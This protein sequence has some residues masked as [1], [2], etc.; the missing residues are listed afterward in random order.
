MTSAQLQ[1]IRAHEN[2]NTDEI[3]L[4][5]LFRILWQQRVTLMLTALGV[6]AAAVVYV[7]VSTPVY[8]VQSVLRPPH[9]RDLDAINASG[10][11][12]LSPDESLRRVGAA[13]ESYETRLDFFRRYPDW[14]ETLREP[15]HSL[16]QSFELFNRDAFQILQP[17]PE[18]DRNL[19][20][21]VGIQLRYP[22]SM[23]GS[24]I[25]NE[26]VQHALA[27]QRQVIAEDIRI[28]VGNRLNDLD[29][30]I[31]AARAA[32]DADK[33]SRIAHLTEADQLRRAQLEDE[34]AALREAL[35]RRR[36]N[37]IAQLDE[38]IIIAEA[39][40]IIKPTTPSRMGG[41]GVQTSQ[42]N[43][44][45]TEVSS[46]QIPLYF[47]G[48][49]NLRAEREA[50]AARQSDDF[51]EPRISEIARELKLLEHNR[52]VEVLQQRE[53]EDLF[54]KEV[55]EWSK[56]RARLKSLDL[57]LEA[58]QL[59]NIDRQAVVPTTPVHPRKA[60]IL[61]LAVMLGGMAGVM[62]ALIRA[63]VVRQRSEPLT[64][65]P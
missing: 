43:V 63:M 16:E 31:A 18:R 17:D 46:R 47:M 21:Y 29:R 22:E 24:V 5:D 54:L 10:V 30:R 33:Q 7:V 60:L 14:F 40:N 19:S 1:A 34:L 28:L 58:V 37:R 32:Y 23:D 6:I 59:V 57:D 52:Q 53:E 50:L 8:E 51:T 2:K 20:R 13:L 39:L 44:I 25:V 15:G 36:H 61:A 12:K 56:E 3:D 38:A 62:A 64:A 55:A 42:G 26:L 27:E 45:H 11:Y 35:H 65:E 48:A 41:D 4:L 49:E 9:I